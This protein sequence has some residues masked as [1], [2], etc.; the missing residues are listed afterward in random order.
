M[1]TAR[2]TRGGWIFVALRKMELASLLREIRRKTRTLPE[3][4]I[5]P[6]QAIWQRWRDNPE[7][8]ENKTLMRVARAI[9]EKRSDFDDADIWALSQEALGLLDALIERRVGRG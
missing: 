1:Q 5:D 8:L 4:Q 9:E 3:P 6:L 2:R 7:S